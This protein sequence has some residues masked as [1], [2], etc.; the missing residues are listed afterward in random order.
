MPD[1]INYEHRKEETMLRF[2]R[3]FGILCILLALPLFLSGMPSQAQAANVS[4]ASVS[5]MVTAGQNW[6]LTRQTPA[7]YDGSGNYLSGGS[8]SDSSNG[9]PIATT[10]FAVAALLETGFNR[11]DQHIKD[12]IAYLRSTQSA[13]VN[14]GSG[15]YSSGGNFGSGY[16]SNY[17]HSSALVAMS[18]YNDPADLARIQG[19]YD[20]AKKNQYLVNNSYFGGWTYDGVGSGDMSNTQFAVMGLAYA[21][22][23]L[24]INA[25]TQTWATNVNNFVQR[26]FDVGS[27]G[28]IAYTPSGSFT[29][30]GSMTAAGIWTLALTGQGTSPIVN[31]AIT[32]YS[33]NYLNPSTQLPWDGNPGTYYNWSS[34]YAYYYY[35]FGMAKALTATRAAD[36]ILG[37]VGWTTS[38]VQDLKNTMYANRTVQDASNN[39]WAGGGSLDGGN[40]LATSWVLMSLAFASPSTESPDKLLPAQANADFAV[41][42]V[43]TLHSTGGVTISNASRGNTD[44]VARR[45]DTIRL[46]VGSFNFTLNHVPP[47]GSTVLTIDLPAQVPGDPSGNNFFQKDGVTPK[48]GLNWFKVVNGSWLGSGIPIILD[49]V[50]NTMKITLVDNGPADASATLGVIV[51]PGAPGFGAAASGPE[52]SGGGGGSGCFIATAAFGSYMAPDVMVLRSFRDNH[53]LTNSFGKAFVRLYYKFSPPLAN[54]IAKHESLRTATRVALTPVVYSV[55]YPMGLFLFAGL[56]IGLVVYRR[57]SK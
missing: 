30:G 28:S 2:L 10:A 35:V 44:G 13:V 54:Y 14:D 29:P 7:T 52:S 31:T 25:G 34:T 1:D 16:D 6:L 47:G 40:E 50:A 38:W 51:D 57:K 23:Y 12:G 32:W 55:K 4:D 39:Y 5:A 36:V 42:G 26:C 17:Y 15:N 27:G 11:A 3:R 41:T 48:A 53:L 43:V 9:A 19:G 21:A 37:P 33:V 22:K 8:W 46:P 45:A 18:L 56:M 20:Y 49:P 24:G